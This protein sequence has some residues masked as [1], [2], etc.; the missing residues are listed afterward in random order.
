MNYLLI[1]A[2]ALLLGAW[3]NIHAKRSKE[4]NKLQQETQEIVLDRFRSNVA[5][6]RGDGK[7]AKIMENRDD[8]PA[9]NNRSRMKVYSFHRKDTR[10]AKERRKSRVQV[11]ITYEI[12]DRRQSVGA[13][14]TGPERRSGVDRRGKYWDRRK[15]VAFQS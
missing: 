14:Y 5:P 7:P 2:L 10:S 1:F 3:I 13:R 4:K 6:V 8:L 12:I 9:E 15:P 11:G